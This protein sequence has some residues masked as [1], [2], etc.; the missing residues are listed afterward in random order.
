MLKDYIAIP[1]SLLPAEFFGG[2][3]GT[4]IPVKFGTKYNATAGLSASQL[5]FSS[6]YIVGLKAAKELV[7]L[8][9]INVY[10]NKTELSFFCF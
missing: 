6:D 9:K 5:V 3:A 4:F 2:P 10:R 8:A 1:T 7:N